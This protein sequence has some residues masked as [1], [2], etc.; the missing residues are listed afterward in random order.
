MSFSSVQSLVLCVTKHAV[1]LIVQYLYVLSQ[2][3]IPNNHGLHRSRPIL[4]TPQMDPP[5]HLGHRIP[6]GCILDQPAY[7][8]CSKSHLGIFSRPSEVVVG[9]SEDVVCLGWTT[10]HNG[11]SHFFD[12]LYRFLHDPICAKRRRIRA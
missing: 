1:E 12:I 11:S 2:H 4:P 6:L 10:S 7:I 8:L 3:K 5:H 9:S